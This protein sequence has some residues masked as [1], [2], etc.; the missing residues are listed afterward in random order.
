MIFCASLQ[1]SLPYQRQSEVTAQE[2]VQVMLEHNE[3]VGIFSD[4]ALISC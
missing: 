2:S 3:N 4:S 1:T